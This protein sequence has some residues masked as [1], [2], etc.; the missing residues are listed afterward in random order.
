[1]EQSEDKQQ[2]GITLHLPMK[3]LLLLVAFILG[4]P[5]GGYTYATKTGGT[6]AATTTAVQNQ[7]DTLA[8]VLGGIGEQLIELNTGQ[9]KNTKLIEANNQAHLD[10]MDSLYS[11]TMDFARNIDGYYKGRFDQMKDQP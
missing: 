4:V 10:R 7:T 1:M 2:S 5:V 3:H 9:H 6:S 8:T 11:L